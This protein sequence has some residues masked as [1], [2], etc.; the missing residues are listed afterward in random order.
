M[1]GFSAPSGLNLVK[2]A[3][4]GCQ[5]TAWE[6]YRQGRLTGNGETTNGL[7]VLKLKAETLGVVAQGLNAPN[8]EVDPLLAVEDL[9]AVL[10]VN[11]GVGAVVAPKTS[12]QTGSTDSDIDGSQVRLLGRRAGGL[13]SGLGGG[14]CRVLAEALSGKREFLTE[15]NRTWKLTDLLEGLRVAKGLTGEHC[16]NQ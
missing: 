10:G 6:R 5:W 11:R 15:K 9:G 16:G 3:A 1:T 14:L 8:L 13:R 2:R 4:E 12:P 7:L